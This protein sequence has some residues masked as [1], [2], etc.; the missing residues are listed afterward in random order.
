MSGL[1]IKCKRFSELNQSGQIRNQ[2]ESQIYVS[3]S[4]SVSASQSVS[5]AV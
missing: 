2:C 4:M 5:E 1:Q 3:M